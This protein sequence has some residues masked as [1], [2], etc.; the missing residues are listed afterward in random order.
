MCSTMLAQSIVLPN[1]AGPC[2]QSHLTPERNSGE[3]HSRNSRFS[4]IQQQ[5]PPRRRC[6]DVSYPSSGTCRS[7][8]CK[9]CRIWTVLGYEEPVKAKSRRAPY[10]QVTCLFCRSQSTSYLLG[11]NLELSVLIDL[12][13]WSESS[14]LL[15]PNLRQ[16]DGYSQHISL[17]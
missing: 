7:H 11:S 1:P 2:I 13:S 12:I 16:Q 8:A 14:Y 17:A 3:A 4:R 5:V 6:R 9:S 15:E 10:L